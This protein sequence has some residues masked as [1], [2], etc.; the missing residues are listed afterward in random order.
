M[1]LTW[2]ALEWCRS[3]KLR[4]SKNLYKRQSKSIVPTRHKEKNFSF[5]FKCYNLTIHAINFFESFCI[6]SPSSLGLDLMV[7]IAKQRKT[8][9]VYAS[10]ARNGRFEHFLEENELRPLGLTTR[11]PPSPCVKMVVVTFLMKFQWKM[12]VRFITECC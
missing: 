12:C 9:I 7:K 1:Y 10:W 6:Y 5:H 8:K 4:S 2:C 3:S 11:W